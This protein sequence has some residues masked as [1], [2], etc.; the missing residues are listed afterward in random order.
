MSYM[1][2]DVEST[3]RLLSDMTDTSGKDLYQHLSEV[4]GYLMVHYPEEALDKFEE[5][6]YLCKN[7]DSLR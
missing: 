3:K 4:F 1:L 7:K 5:V 6:S 2:K